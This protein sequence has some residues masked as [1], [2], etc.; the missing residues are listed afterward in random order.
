MNGWVDK[1]FNLHKT[2]KYKRTRNH[3]T[4]CKARYTSA[5]CVCVYMQVLAE[6][7]GV[8]S[9][10]SWVI[11]KCESELLARHMTAGKETVHTLQL[12]TYLPSTSQF[13]NYV[14][15]YIFC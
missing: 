7:R 1:A 12:L 8:R 6:A 14:P 5:E 3:C 10:W 2:R 15:K 11:A 4:P 9:F 13:L